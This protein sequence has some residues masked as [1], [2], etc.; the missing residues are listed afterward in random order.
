MPDGSFGCSCQLSPS[1][2]PCADLE[3]GEHTSMLSGRWKAKVADGVLECVSVC[4]L[5]GV[6]E[7]ALAFK[8]DKGGIFKTR[9]LYFF[10]A[11]VLL[12]CGKRLN[13]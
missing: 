8:L 11:E 12:F 9:D 2:S 5:R 3:E 4:S 13:S 10:V 1:Y 6:K 7:D